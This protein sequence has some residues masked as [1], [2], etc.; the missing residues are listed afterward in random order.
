MSDPSDSEKVLD[1]VF[2]LL[3]P[4]PPPRR[5]GLAVALA[6]A[7]SAFLAASDT[8]KFLSSLKVVWTSRS[9]VMS[10]ESSSLFF[11]T[12]PSIL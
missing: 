6:A 11:S 2:F 10:G 1:T 12:K 9:A 5:P 4:P 8:A 3:P 7:A